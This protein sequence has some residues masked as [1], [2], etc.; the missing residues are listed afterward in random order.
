MQFGIDKD[1]LSQHKRAKGY[2]Y[3]KEKIKYKDYPLIIPH[4][5]I[6]YRNKETI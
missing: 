3:E 4:N 6:I 5:Q 1:I 2:N